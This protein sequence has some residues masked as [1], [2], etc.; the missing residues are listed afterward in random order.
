MPVTVVDMETVTP[1][2]G[3]DSNQLR[4]TSRLLVHP[5]D[6]SDHSFV[7]NPLSGS[8]DLADSSEV[9][10]L[11]S[12]Q[13]GAD[14]ALVDPGFA[15]QLRER[16]MAFRSAEEEEIYL[17][18]SVARA[19]N[20][21][22]QA[23]PS[24]YT[25]C[26]TLA[27]NLACGYCFEGDSLLDKPQGVMSEPQVDAVMAS[28]KELEIRDRQQQGAVE[29][30]FPAW[31][32]LFGGEPL[33]PSTRACVERILAGA[34]ELGMFIG[35]T[36]NG[37]NIRHFEK[38][39]T[40]YGGS[41][42]AFQVTL[43]GPQAVHDS[44]RHRLGGQGTFNE[45]VAG[46]DILLEIPT[47]VHLRVNLDSANIDSLPELCDF[48]DSRG[49]SDNPLVD[50]AVAA[51][52]L[53][54]TGGCQS[55]YNGALTELEVHKRLL[56]LMKAF[57]VVAKICKPSHLRHLQHLAALLE[58]QDPMA[59]QRTSTGVPGP[60]YWYCEQGT[61]KQ[62]VFTP[63]GYI[64]TCTEAVGKP[65]HAI[66]RFDPAL[67]IWRG[68][69]SNWLGRTILSH[70]KCRSCQISTLCG[71]GCHFAARE[72]TNHAES[73]LI[74][75]SAKRGAPERNVDGADARGKEIEPFCAAAEDI[76]REYLTQIGAKFIA[77]GVVSAAHSSSS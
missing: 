42:G 16:K 52:T 38:I 40:R 48:V 69:A 39:L 33:L 49:W 34:E 25:I 29:P 73:S 5:I 23:T 59:V 68:T 75:I 1:V 51:V 30:T 2:S 28:I 6:G 70:P 77:R 22:I 47:T 13:I 54:S 32:A 27:C 21:C 35:C 67:D 37:V 55:K 41:L 10:L 65:A 14:E 26:P 64:Y 24:M 15:K 3:L 4:V 57:P 61:G 66:G 36:T 7:F 71:G 74:Q 12:L 19:R 60:R 20:R 11:R 31:V 53:H 45:I 18:D 76:V 43:D 46:I 56:E 62:W 58:P 9:A 17:E 50:M 63:D 72:L 44:R 8:V